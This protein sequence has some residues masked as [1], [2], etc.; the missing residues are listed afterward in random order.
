MTCRRC[1]QRVR[2]KRHRFQG[3]RRADMHHA[4]PARK[5]PPRFTIA[6]KH[7]GIDPVSFVDGTRERI[8]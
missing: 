7:G 2:V 5:N 3:G 6:V 4:C 1:G 8:A